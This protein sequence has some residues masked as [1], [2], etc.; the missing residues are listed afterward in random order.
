MSN[1]TSAMLGEITINIAII[2]PCMA[3]PPHDSERDQGRKD[4]HENA[5]NTTMKN[6]SPRDIGKKLR[7]V[8]SAKRALDCDSND[9]GFLSSFTE[10]CQLT[11][12]FV[13]D[14][15]LTRST[16]NPGFYLPFH[17]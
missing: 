17:D 2:Q 14:M 11:H 1:R 9:D 5:S 16:R 13:D 6:K 15:L 4:T 7:I 10:R 3:I 8:L 12:P